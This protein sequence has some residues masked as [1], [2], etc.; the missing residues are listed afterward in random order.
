MQVLSMAL[1]M[2][3]KGESEPKAKEKERRGIFTT[4]IISELETR[5]VVSLFYTGEKHA[6]ENLEAL[7]A[8]RRGELS[9]PIQMSDAL[10]WNL[11]G[12]L[13]TIVSHCLVHARRNFVDVKNGFPEQ[14]KHVLELLAKVYMNDA[15]SK[16]MGLGA[17]ERLLLHQQKSQPHMDELEKWMQTELDQKR[18]EPNSGLGKAIAYMKKHWKTL[19]VFLREPGAPLDN[20]ICERALKKAI[21]HRKN[22]LFYKTENGAKVGDLFMSLIHTAELAGVDAFPYLVALLKQKKRVAE[23]PGRWLPWNYQESLAEVESEG[24]RAG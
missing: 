16:Q 4:G 11:P 13:Q 15:E 12:E 3:R 18:V 2:R 20:N 1:E 19:T 9:P 10:S 7:L 17:E 21:L 24:A 8:H 22:A 14:V 5:Q 6:G 23:E